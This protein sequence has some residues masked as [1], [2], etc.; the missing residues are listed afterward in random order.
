M[1]VKLDYKSGSE[2]Q[3]PG[4]LVRWSLLRDELG[5]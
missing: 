1:A 4:L 3:S 5:V 2:S